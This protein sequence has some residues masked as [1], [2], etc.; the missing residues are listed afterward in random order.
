MSD[1][2][3]LSPQTVLERLR[4]GQIILIDVR[5]PREFAVDRIHGALMHPLST[6]DSRAIPTDSQRQIV[7]QCGS[8]V[9][10]RKALDKFKTE[11]GIASAHLEGGIGAWKQAGLPCIQ[12]NAAT[13]EVEDHGKY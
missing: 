8:G 13:G 5:E 9:R 3:N 6:F 4:A 11:T 10:S 1:T 7:F 2:E 12:I